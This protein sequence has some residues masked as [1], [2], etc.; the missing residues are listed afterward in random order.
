MI[1]D[2]AKPTDAAS[3]MSWPELISPPNGRT[4]TATPTKPSNT[5]MF[6]HR[7]MRSPRKVTAMI[8]TQ[9]GM[10]NSIETTWASEIR[11]SA[12]SHP[13]CAA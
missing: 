6:F 12:T 1:T 7:P 13:H 3:A 11:L 8:A 9:I 4:M 2:A 10:V 5:A